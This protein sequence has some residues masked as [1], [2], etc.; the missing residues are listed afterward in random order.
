MNKKRNNKGF[1]LVELIVVIAVMA[2]LVVVLAP[3]YLRYVEKS[4]VQKDASAFSEVVNA[5]KIVA[6]EEEVYEEIGEDTMVKIDKDGVITVAD[7][8]L[9]EDETDDGKTGD[10]YDEIVA[11]VGATVEFTS[12]AVEEYFEDDD[13]TI[14]IEIVKENDTLKFDITGPTAFADI[15]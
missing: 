15:K 6:S 3:A 2:V 7:V 1:S 12:D 9:A 11:T 10:L 13:T 5:I 8:E 4:R 14:D